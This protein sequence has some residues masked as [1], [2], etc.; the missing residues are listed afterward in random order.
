MTTKSQ[1]KTELKCKLMRKKLKVT[2]GGKEN[3]VRR[4]RRSN[5]RT[6]ENLIVRGTLGMGQAEQGKQHCNDYEVKVTGTI[7]D[8]KRA[9]S[10]L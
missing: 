8:V 3:Q 9:T 6:K 4:I 7:N 5:M 2:R 10:F 1:L